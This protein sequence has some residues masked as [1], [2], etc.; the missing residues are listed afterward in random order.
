MECK[1]ERIFKNTHIAVNVKGKKIISIK[2]TDEHVHD[3][4][5]QS[6]T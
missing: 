2:V 6:V 3:D 5:L 1:K 4:R